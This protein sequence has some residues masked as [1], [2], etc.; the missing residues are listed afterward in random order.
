MTIMGSNVVS[1]WHTVQVLL[2]TYSFAYG[3][4]LVIT[5][6]LYYQSTTTQRDMN[7]PSVFAFDK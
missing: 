1:G 4:I 5:Y 6:Y 2:G 3:G 7:A